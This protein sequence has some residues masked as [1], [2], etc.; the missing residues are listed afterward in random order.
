MSQPGETSTGS[1]FY[2][3]DDDDVH[4]GNYLAKLVRALRDE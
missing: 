3:Y 4:P 1:H 2:A